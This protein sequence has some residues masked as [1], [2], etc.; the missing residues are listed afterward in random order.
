MSRVIVVA[1]SYRD[2]SGGRMVL[3]KLVDL[4]LFGGI[5][6]ALYPWRTDIGSF[7]TCPRYLSAVTAKVGADDLVIYPDIV[8][9]NPIGA[10]RTARW[11][12]YSPR[13]PATPGEPVLCYSEQ[14]GDGPVL[15]VADPRTDIFYDSRCG[16]TRDVCWTWR[17]AAKQGWS[18]ADKPK[19]G[20][21]ITK[22]A[23]ICDAANAFCTHE[24]FDCYDNASYLAI[25]ARLCGC[26]VRV[27]SKTPVSSWLSQRIAMTA[28]D[29]RADVIA[30]ERT[31]GAI[32]CRVIANLLD[33]SR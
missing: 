12:L 22:D 17:K 1:P 20:T 14:F 18:D 23:S 7:A 5:D 2:T 32:A 24:R 25:Q 21:E 29:L 33:T 6:A 19:T 10:R 13:H 27:I 3:H 16:R 15:Q 11:L 8:R 4:L 28:D 9:G 26:D 30:S 31:Q